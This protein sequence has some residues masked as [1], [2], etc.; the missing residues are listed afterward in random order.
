VKNFHNMVSAQVSRILSEAGEDSEGEKGEKISL[1]EATYSDFVYLD[2]SRIPVMGKGLQNKA[3]EELVLENC[4]FDITRANEIVFDTHKIQLILAKAL[5]KPPILAEE[6]NFIPFEFEFSGSNQKS[7]I[8]AEKILQSLKTESRSEVAL[9][10]TY[11]KGRFPDKSSKDKEVIETVDKLFL[12]IVDMVEFLKVRLDLEDLNQTIESK[13][14]GQQKE[15][16]FRYENLQKEFKDLE[17]EE[18]DW[19]VG[20]LPQ[21]YEEV[22]EKAVDSLVKDRLRA[23]KIGE[24]EARKISSLFADHG[25]KKNSNMVKHLEAA[26]KEKAK[27]NYPDMRF[28][29]QKISYAESEFLSIEEECMKENHPDCKPNNQECRSNNAVCFNEIKDYRIDQFGCLL[30]ILK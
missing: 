4:M 7:R 14:K 29:E 28:T 20:D 21:L 30:D 11:L 5:Y 13:M 19:R 16:Y 24:V 3:I 18:Q 10:Q 27:D 1:E 23:K 8:D 25:I 15:T 22:L 26:I 2:T 6:D 17:L 12:F 9:L